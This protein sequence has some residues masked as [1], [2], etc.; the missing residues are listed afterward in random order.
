MLMAPPVFDNSVTV[1]WTLGMQ[2][3]TKF[4]PSRKGGGGKVSWGWHGWL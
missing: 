4:K 1:L 2:Q 3:V